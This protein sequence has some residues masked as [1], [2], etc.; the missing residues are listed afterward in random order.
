MN[1]AGVAIVAYFLKRTIHTF[2]AIG[3]VDACMTVLAFNQC[4]Y[5][6]QAP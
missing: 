4:L 6:Y 2:P 1:V 5:P 3:R